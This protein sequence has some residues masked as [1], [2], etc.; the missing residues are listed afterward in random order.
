MSV[1]F[2]WFSMVLPKMALFIGLKKSFSK[3]LAALA[4]LGAEPDIWLQPCRLGE[5]ED[6]MD[7]R[8]LHPKI[9]ALLKIAV[10]DDVFGLVSEVRHELRGRAAD[11][12]L[13]V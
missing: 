9:C 1:R 8:Q 12:E 2:F 6:A 3:G 5:V 13:I 11:A 7:S 4:L 10:V